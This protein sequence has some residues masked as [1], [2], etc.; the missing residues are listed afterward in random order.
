[1]SIIYPL[2]GVAREFAELGV[3]L[4][5]G[6]IVGCRHCC[7]P[8]VKRITREQFARE[9]H[10]RKNVL[11]ELERKAKAMEGDPREIGV[12]PARTPINRTKRRG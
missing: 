11:T 4:Y 8:P 7:S 1:M 3:N 2:R 5:S 6:C 10:P 9:A 12:C